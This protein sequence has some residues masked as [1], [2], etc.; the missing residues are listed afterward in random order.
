MPRAT[1]TS[2]AFN[3]VAEPRRRLLIDVLACHSGCAVNDR[4][5]CS[6]VGR[7]RGAKLFWQK[8]HKPCECRVFGWE[9]EIT[10]FGRLIDWWNFGDCDPIQPQIPQSEL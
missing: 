9:T 7:N 1:A 6:G 5:C 3:A 2:D 8:T 4:V 10:G